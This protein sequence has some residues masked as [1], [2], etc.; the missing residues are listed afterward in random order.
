MKRKRLSHQWKAYLQFRLTAAEAASAHVPDDVHGALDAQNLESMY[1]ACDVCEQVW[2]DCH[3]TAC[4][5][6]PVVQ[7]APGGI[8]VRPD[9]N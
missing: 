8:P 7:V 4:P 5:G 2:A 1:V 3:G 9:G 6:A